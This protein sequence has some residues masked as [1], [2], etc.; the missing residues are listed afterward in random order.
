MKN[1]QTF[2]LLV[3]SPINFSKHNHLKMPKEQEVFEA[4]FASTVSGDRRDSL[5]LRSAVVCSMQVSS[6]V[7]GGNLFMPYFITYPKNFQ[8]VCVLLFVF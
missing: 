2:Y 5:S 6:D 1:E 4:L 8:C 3:H 7:G